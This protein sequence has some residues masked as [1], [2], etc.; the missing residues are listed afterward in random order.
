MRSR[1]TGT[2]I[3]LLVLFTIRLNAEDLRVGLW[4]VEKDSTSLVFV[5]EGVILISAK[6]SPDGNLAAVLYEKD[7]NQNA[8]LRVIDLKSS[9]ILWQKEM[10]DS[11][12]EAFRSQL[13]FSPDSKILYKENRNYEDHVNNHFHLLAW[14]SRN[15]DSI[16][17]IEESSFPGEYYYSFDLSSGQAQI[18]SATNDSLLIYQI[19]EKRVVKILNNNPTHFMINFTRGYVLG[20]GWDHIVSILPLTGDTPYSFNPYMNWPGPMDIDIRGSRIVIGGADKIAIWEKSGRDWM[21]KKYRYIKNF[22]VFSRE[23]QGDAGVYNVYQNHSY[24]DNYS[25]EDG[26]SGED[27]SQDQAQESQGQRPGI[28]YTEILTDV[29]MTA[30]GKKVLC[31]TFNPIQ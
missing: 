20:A 16:S 25:D 3:L 9:S 6:I 30:D 7:W 11:T 28:D 18:I 5:E 15:G 21:L 8:S 19:D 29:S 23:S 12:D 2:V 22:L 17:P 13:H 4:D 26:Y 10:E 31:Y 1:I 14:N 27:E 24:D